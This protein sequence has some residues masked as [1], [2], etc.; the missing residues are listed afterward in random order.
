MT[1]AGRNMGAAGLLLLLAGLI[2]RYPEV[3]GCGLACLAALGT[4]AAVAVTC[5]PSVVVSRH[6][7]QS[8]VTE[9][10]SARVVVSFTNVGRRRSLPLVARG[11]FDNYAFEVGIPSLGPRTSREA[12][13]VLETSRR[14]VYPVGPF[15]VGRCDPLRLVR[16]VQSELPASVLWVHPRTCKLGPLPAGRSS[17]VDGP[18]F[19]A[20]PRGGVTF[21]SLRKY[22]TGNDLRL[23]HWKA[24]ARAGT[25]LVRNNVVPSEPR[26]T[27]ILDNDGGG[28]AGDTFEEAVRITASLC[29]TASHAGV[30]VS[31]RTTRGE[32]ASTERP[33]REGAGLLDLLATTETYEPGSGRAW[34]ATRAGHLPGLSLIFVTGRVGS[35]TLEALRIVCR[36]SRSVTV[37]QVCDPTE[38]APIP[39]A[40]VIAVRSAD[41][42][43]SAWKKTAA[44]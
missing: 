24:S 5:R 32:L 36:R 16:I 28:Y 19:D 22:E 11:R 8:R 44:R 14:G 7:E 40:A 42:F 12:S 23:V 15:T 29:M 4:A 6:L 13:C 9:G 26:L 21:H 18:T 38:S 2:T 41:G 30:P 25:L 35:G 3:V 27:V 43:E 17:A 33:G 1:G 37:V 31:L 39:G 20:S 34:L 10:T